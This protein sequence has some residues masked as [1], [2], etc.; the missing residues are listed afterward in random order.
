M[1]KSIAAVALLSFIAWQPCL[2]Q[3]LRAMAYALP[4]NDALMSAG[5]A[6]DGGSVM[7]LLILNEVGTNF[8]HVVVKQNAALEVEWA[9]QYS[10]PLVYGGGAILAHDDGFVLACEAGVNSLNG[11]LLFLDGEGEMMQL[12]GIGALQPIAIDRAANGDYLICGWGSVTTSS[13]GYSVMAAAAVSATGDFLWSQAYDTG[14]PGTAVRIVPTSDGGALVLGLISGGPEGVASAFLKLDLDGNMEWARMLDNPGPDNVFDALENAEGYLMVGREGS[15]SMSLFQLGPDGNL[16]WSRGYQAFLSGWRILAAPGGG[17]AI[18]CV[19]VF[20]PEWLDRFFPVNGNVGTCTG[21]VN[22]QGQYT[23]MSTNQEFGSDAWAY[24]V[25]DNAIGCVG[26]ATIIEH[27]SFSVQTAPLTL[28]IIP[29]E[30]GSATMPAIAPFA[31]AGTLD[32]ETDPLAGIPDRAPEGSLSVHPMPASS[33]VTIAGD[34]LKQLSWTDAIGRGIAVS[35]IERAGAVAADVSALPQ[36]T[37]YARDAEGRSV[38][39][40]VAR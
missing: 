38:R 19:N 17:Y 29:Q 13:G 35:T 7:D 5:P 40:L 28:T 8:S 33:V 6:P 25:A 18:V 4:T 32:C 34:R 1:R 27:A 20:E 2:A 16:L 11:Q 23:L 22:A 31:I 10:W 21:W 24:L 15:N 12:T 9:K 26:R 36:G 30:Q 39:V 14:L 37:Y 3:P